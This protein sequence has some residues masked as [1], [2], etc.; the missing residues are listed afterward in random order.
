MLTSFFNRIWKRWLIAAVAMVWVS[1][2]MAANDISAGYIL[3]GI[4]TAIVCV[5]MSALYG[6]NDE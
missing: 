2:Y 5:V 3:P 4:V 6:S 1:G